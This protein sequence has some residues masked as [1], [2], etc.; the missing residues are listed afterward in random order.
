MQDVL[1]FADIEAAAR[2]I[3]AEVRRTPV[4]TCPMLDAELGAQLFFKCENLQE[5]GAF[6]LRG[7][8]NAVLSLPDAALRRGVATHSSGNH[9]TALALA[10]RRR[11]LPA[12]VV[13]P[14]NSSAFKQRAVAEHGAKIILCAPTQAAREAAL[15]KYVADTGATVVHPYNDP[16]IMAG[17]GTAAL[18]LHEQIP[19]LDVVLAPLGGGGLLSGTAV[20]T[21][22][23]RPKAQVVGVEP[24]GADDA[25]RSLQAGRI[26]PVPH[27]ETVADGL[28]ATIGTL[29]F[30]VIRADVDQVLRVDDPAIIAAM[31]FVWERMKI[32]IEPS[33]AVVVAALRE[34]LLDVSGKRVGV[35]LSGGNL[36]LDH[37]PWSKT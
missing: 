29:T 7:A 12:C 11:G 37:L 32:V 1:S 8:S 14:E 2:R 35:I 25:W 6:K 18:E 5:M 33:A 9:G 20:A 13:M 28:R 31:R 22:T 10:A 4:M 30:K 15:E 3:A 17:Q 27:P 19:D 23:L 21:R 16:A 34:R 26:E 36:D 24:R